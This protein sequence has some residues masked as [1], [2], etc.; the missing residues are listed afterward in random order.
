[1]DEDTQAWLDV[2]DLMAGFWVWQRDEKMHPL[3]CRAS[4]HDEQPSRPELKLYAVRIDCIHLYCP[5]CQHWQFIKPKD[6]LGSLLM[7]Y[8]QSKMSKGELPPF[9][10]ITIN[11]EEHVENQSDLDQAK[12]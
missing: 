11:E 4:V 3:T 12:V 6:H 1:M 7:G 8:G 10:T 2:L 9:A 5:Q